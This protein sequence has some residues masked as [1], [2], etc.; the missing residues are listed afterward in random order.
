MQRPWRTQH[1]W[2]VV[3]VATVQ[4]VFL[5][6][7]LLSSC[8]FTVVLQKSLGT[9]HLPEHTWLDTTCTGGS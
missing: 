7:R 9:E 4:C 3:L 2:A 1:S 5:G 6:L 8:L